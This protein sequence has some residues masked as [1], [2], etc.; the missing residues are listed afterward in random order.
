M[1]VTITVKV[2]RIRTKVQIKLKCY[3]NNF[4]KYVHINQYKKRMY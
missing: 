3:E 1:L 4:Q 2:A